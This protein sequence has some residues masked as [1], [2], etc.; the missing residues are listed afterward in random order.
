MAS[1]VR[2][3]CGAHREKPQLVYK[4][5]ERVS[6]VLLKLEPFACGSGSTPSWRSNAEW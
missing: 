1:V 4:V 6:P 3:R 2:S 5:I